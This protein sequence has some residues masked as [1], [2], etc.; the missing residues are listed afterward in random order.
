MNCVVV[1]SDSLSLSFSLS[2]SLALHLLAF[3][4]PLPQSPIQY[5]KCNGERKQQQSLAVRRFRHQCSRTTAA[6]SPTAA[7][8][9]QAMQQ[10]T[11][12]VL[13]PKIALNRPAQIPLCY[14]SFGF[15]TPDE[16]RWRSP[17]SGATPTRLR[18]RKHAHTV[19]KRRRR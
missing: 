5:A 17:L 3:A 12:S 2:L 13:C 16:C 10:H 14:C 6:A 7:A 8:A 9:V 1:F 4:N 11:R 18:G 19:A 15:S